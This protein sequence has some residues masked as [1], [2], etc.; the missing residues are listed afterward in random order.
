M[1][2]PQKP[3]DRFNYRYTVLTDA[4]DAIENELKGK[5]PYKAKR[6]FARYFKGKKFED[7][8]EEARKLGQRTITARHHSLLQRIKKMERQ[9]FKS[10]A[11]QQEA[12][13]D[14]IP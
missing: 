3:E 10:D 9:I 2:N 14:K 6:L 5:Y 7:N 12:D 8:M 13:R 11:K 4:A 1:P